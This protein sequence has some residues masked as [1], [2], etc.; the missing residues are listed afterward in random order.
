[1][2]LSSV[3]IYSNKWMLNEGRGII[4]SKLLVFYHLTLAT[5]MTQILARTTSILDGRHKMQMKPI[6]Y[7]RTVVPIGLFYGLSLVSSNEVYLHLS[8][9]FIQ[10]LKVRLSEIYVPVTLIYIEIC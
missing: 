5:L 2:G 3:M 6:L 10:M 4:S 9:A 7:I 1:M 8:V